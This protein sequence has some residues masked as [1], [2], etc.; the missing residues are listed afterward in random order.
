MNF[1]RRLRFTHLGQKLTFVAFATYGTLTLVFCGFLTYKFEQAKT[2]NIAEFKA[3]KAESIAL[4]LSE[5]MWKFDQTSTL[6]TTRAFLNTSGEEVAAVQVHDLD[7]KAFIDLS[8]PKWADYQEDDFNQL[9][10]T[11]SS[12]VTLN[13]EN[14]IVGSVTIYYDFSALYLEHRQNI[15]QVLAISGLLSLACLIWVKF[16]LSSSLTKPLSLLI[17]KLN[18]SE[19]EGFLQ[20]LNTSLPYE[21]NNIAK[22]FDSAIDSVIKNELILKDYAVNLESLVIE[23]TQELELSRAKAL[24]S[25]QM[26]A[27]GEMSAGVAHEI[28]N[29]L[30]VI[31]GKVR[32]L[33]HELEKT[34]AEAKILGHLEKIDMMSKRIGKIVKGMRSFSRDSSQEEITTFPLNTFLD[35]IKDL[36]FYRFQNKGV[37][38]TF[39]APSEP[40]VLE[41]RQ[42]QLSQ[43]LVN[44]INNAFDA[45]L[46]LNERWVQVKV[47]QEPNGVLFQ[48]IDSGAGLT[49]DFAKK[50]MQPFFTTKDVGQGTGLGLS[51]SFGIIQSFNS[52]LFVNH[53]MKN[54]C[55]QFL[56]PQPLVLDKKQAA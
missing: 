13:Y 50:I 20:K 24:H 45:I 21:F 22:A 54:T 27:L 39:T 2:Q 40:V 8:K 51:I 48:V 3:D 4:A 43:V 18:Q 55:F 47:S 11:D 23:R 31:D 35:E 6:K 53:E 49:P 34:Q 17:E 44:L 38:L 56:L 32:V 41:A 15:F 26:A 42:V 46:P 25:S 9:A 16:I 33:K 28:N 36:C 5:S 12:T 52:E 19:R 10:F 30:T 29:P 14:S 7:G 37:E 1:F